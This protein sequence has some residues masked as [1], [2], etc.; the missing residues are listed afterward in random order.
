[1]TDDSGMPPRVRAW[2]D[3]ELAYAACYA[4]RSQAEPG[5]YVSG[6]SVEELCAAL[7]L[8]ADQLERVK[9]L[10][11]L[12]SELYNG[13]D[14]IIGE[15]YLAAQE[16][17]E[18]MD[19]MYDYMYAA[20]SV[21]KEL[22]PDVV[23]W[24]R[25]LGEFGHEGIDTETAEVMVRALHME[26]DWAVILDDWG[27]MVPTHL[28]ERT[29]W[30]DGEWR[31]Q[32]HELVLLHEAEAEA[33]RQHRATPEELAEW[34][35]EWQTWPRPVKT[36]HAGPWVAKAEWEAF[37]RLKGLSF[38]ELEAEHRRA[39]ER[40]ERL[41]EHRKLAQEREEKM[42]AQL[43]ACEAE[44]RQLQAEYRV[45]RESQMRP[46]SPAQVASAIELNQDLGGR[47]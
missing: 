22:G 14:L 34:K 8:A 47:G 4:G 25:D 30:H 1:M 10:G 39:A 18:R 12:R 23:R 5:E 44:T 27:E 29:V 33:V 26:E 13:E 28:V 31:G 16:F 15:L 7:P 40:S 2:L 45:R 9:I 24:L 11:Q 20:S 6:P 43:D 46:M 19:N 36:D 42:K 38:T 37:L 41:A 35:T 32:E 17:P 3:Y 21:R